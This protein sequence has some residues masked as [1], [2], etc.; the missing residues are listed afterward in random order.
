MYPNLPSPAAVHHEKVGRK[1][2]FAHNICE[3]PDTA[4]SL[5]KAIHAAISV[6]CD[7]RK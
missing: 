1:M 3:R 6:H 5:A 7:R 4:A 2:E